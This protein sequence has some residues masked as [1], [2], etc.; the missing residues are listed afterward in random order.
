MSGGSEL[1]LV[2]SVEISQSEAVFSWPIRGCWTTFFIAG[3]LPG[4]RDSEG[5]VER[6]HK[7]GLQESLREHGHH[8]VSRAAEQSEGKFELQ[9][10]ELNSLL[11][12]DNCKWRIKTDLEIIVM[13]N[14]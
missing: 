14:N 13:S 4:T 10:G 6:K 9:L 12:P 8:E 3:A 2:I 1:W 11:I 5:I 7:D